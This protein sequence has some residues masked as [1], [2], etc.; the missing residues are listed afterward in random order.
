ME[1]SHVESSAFTVSPARRLVRR[2]RVAAIFLWIVLSVCWVRSYSHEDVISWY[3]PPYPGAKIRQAWYLKTGCGGVEFIIQT[4]RPGEI[5]PFPMKGTGID[6]GTMETIPKYPTNNWDASS[7]YGFAVIR[8]HPIPTRGVVLPF[9]FL[10]MTSCGTL[11]TDVVRTLSGRRRPRAG[12]ACSL[13]DST[14][15]RSKHAMDAPSEKLTQTAW[16]RYLMSSCLSHAIRGMSR[17]RRIHSTRTTNRRT[18]AG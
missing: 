18:R 14:D 3:G 5:D 16:D 17:L 15:V 13:C 1:A 2:W 8:F 4:H 7:Y 12:F 10:W 11:L 9:W 6:W